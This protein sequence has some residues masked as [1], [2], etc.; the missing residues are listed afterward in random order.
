PA[1]TDRDDV[2]QGTVLARRGENALEVLQRIRA[3]AVE[4]NKSYL[5]PGVQ[6]VPHYDRTELIDRTLHTVRR[7]MTEGILLVLGVLVLFLGLRNWRAALIVA[8]VIPLAL[9][10]SFMLLDYEHVPANLI[11]LGAIDFGII[12]DAAVV[13]IENVVRLTEQRRLNIREAI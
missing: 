4:I 3:K 6:L 7:N 13:I 10:G 11:S 12:V 2:I 1:M 5:P 8:S 9:L